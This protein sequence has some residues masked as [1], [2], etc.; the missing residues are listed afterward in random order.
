MYFCLISNAFDKSEYRSVIVL[1]CKV[2]SGVGFWPGVK[3]FLLL[4]L[5]VSEAKI[6]ISATFKKMSILT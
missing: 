3:N 1:I 4:L 6:W 2:T 5:K